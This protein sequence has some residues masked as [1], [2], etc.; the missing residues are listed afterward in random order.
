MALKAE[1]ESLSLS[2]A[3]GVNA[4][5]ADAKV[6]KKKKQEDEAMQKVIHQSAQCLNANLV[7]FDICD[8]NADWSNC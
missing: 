1:N 6:E 4:A 7:T 2:A 8:N 5:K 3:G